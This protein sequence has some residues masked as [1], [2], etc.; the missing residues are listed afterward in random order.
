MYCILSKFFLGLFFYATSSFAFFLQFE[1]GS[2]K[3]TLERS[4]KVLLSETTLNHV[5]TKATR[6]FSFVKKTNI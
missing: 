2:D 4:C 1:A 5:N 3:N 6:V